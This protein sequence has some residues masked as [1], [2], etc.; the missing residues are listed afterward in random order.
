[1]SLLTGLQQCRQNDLQQ[2]HVEIDF[3]ILYRM[4]LLNVATPWTMDHLLKKIQD[5]LC[6]GEY[7]V[8]H[9]FRV[10]N[11]VADSLSKLGSS[12]TLLD[13]Y[14]DPITIPGQILGHLHWDCL[15]LPSIRFVTAILGDS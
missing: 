4:V 3:E 5:L 14:F 7:T 15:E 6:Q 10:A 12:R 11:S 1:M 2:V 8:H 13:L 9:I